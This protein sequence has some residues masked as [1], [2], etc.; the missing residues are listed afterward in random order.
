MNGADGYIRTSE[1]KGFYDIWKH[2]EQQPSVVDLSQVLNREVFSGEVH[3]SGGTL[4]ISADA[5]R[6]AD[7]LGITSLLTESLSGMLTEDEVQGITFFSDSDAVLQFDREGRLQSVELS[8]MSWTLG[9]HTASGLCKLSFSDWGQVDKSS[10]EPT[11][12]ALSATVEAD[13]DNLFFQD[14]DEEANGVQSVN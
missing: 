1:Q 8:G 12:E 11:E 2:T 10:V 5:E 13:T 4:Q 6:L 3:S 9:K 7:V 14:S